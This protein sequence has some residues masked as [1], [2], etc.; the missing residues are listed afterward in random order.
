MTAIS[1]EPRLVT[2]LEATASLRSTTSAKFHDMAAFIKK[3]TGSLGA[4][5]CIYAVGCDAA[6]NALYTLATKLK[7]QAGSGILLHWAINSVKKGGIVPIVGVHGLTG[8]MV[9]IGNAVNKD[10]TI[11]ANQASVKRLLPR[12][13]NHVRSGAIHPKAL[14]T[15]RLS[16][17]DVYPQE[18]ERPPLSEIR[19]LPMLHRRQAA[20]RAPG[21][22]E[23]EQRL[24]GCSCS[25]RPEGP[26]CGR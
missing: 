6:G 4:D 2:C 10:I 23:V 8:N 20:L 3:L 5:V 7:L 12:V 13:I 24:S 19:L 14:I 16:L 22:S 9:P 15:H 26:H 25:E 11:R 18:D 21:L 17:E 1:S